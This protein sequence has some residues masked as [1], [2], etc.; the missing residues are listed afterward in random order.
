[1]ASDTPSGMEYREPQGFSISYS[2]DDTDAVRAAWEKLADGGT[3]TMPLDT[4][5]GVDCSAC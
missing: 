1:M 2:G 4:R 5:H 3:V